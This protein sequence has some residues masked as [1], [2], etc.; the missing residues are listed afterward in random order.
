[1]I[2]LAY[3]YAL[4]ALLFIPVLWYYWLRPSAH[5]VI[6]FSGLTAFRSAGATFWSRLRYLPHTLRT[7]ALIALIVAASRPQRADQSMR[8]YI[9]GI[10]IQLVIDRSP[11]MAN[12]DLSPP[13]Q[14]V[15][16]FDVVR[17][18]VRRFVKGDE[19]LPGRPN[20]LIG[21]V[22]FSSFADS[23]CPLTIDHDGIV[24]V[25]DRITLPESRSSEGGTAIG[26]GLAL[27]VDHLR[28]LKRRT[29]S[30]EQFIIKSK[31]AILLTDGED[32]ASTISPETAGELAARCGIKVYT[33]LAG[34]GEFVGYGIQRP[35]EDAALR[36][37][38]ELTGGKF[39]RAMD[40]KALEQVY[41]EIDKLERSRAEERKY[42]DYEELSLPWLA[43]AFGL[44]CVQA[45][46]ES[47]RLRR[48]P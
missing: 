16:R 15:N 30:G 17:G 2:R 6:R 40:K 43:S 20:D 27:A 21:V 7:L 24:N 31:I 45:L 33:I 48:I 36:K 13:G 25:I 29:G 35:V 4:V 38:A 3:P 8:T 12:L 39:Y 11:S 47:T 42:V 44:V 37:I 28:D 18:V 34:T 41:E 32:N 46:L 26:D 9:E 23:L 14:R 10:A 19:K 1:M 5:G 22:T